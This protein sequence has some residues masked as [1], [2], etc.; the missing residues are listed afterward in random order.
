MTSPCTGWEFSFDSIAALSDPWDKLDADVQEIAMVMA[1]ATMRRLTAFA[2]G[3][4]PVTVRPCTEG[5]RATSVRWLQDAPFMDA[6]GNWLNTCGC[7][8]GADCHC[9]GLLSQID[10]V[11]GHSVS[12]V[13]DGEALV[14]GEDFR[15][16]GGRWLVRLG[17][18]AWPAC[19][20][21]SLSEGDGTFLVT[22]T[23]GLPVGTFGRVAGS[24]LAL[25]MAK[26]LKGAADCALP[27]G[28]TQIVRQGVTMQLSPS[29]F[30][31]GV[32][33]IPAVDS[34]IAAV[35]PNG[36]RMQPTIWSPQQ[37]TFRG[38][39]TQ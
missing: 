23:P 1:G 37:Q 28:V 38:G 8:R 25:E 5:C 29:S 21:M 32:T 3:G 6:A 17:G 18:A 39:V 16:D 9:G 34:Y 22:Y 13:L 11:Q 20:D 26:A 7:G 4:C 15:M 27:K 24:F 2:Y 33:G 36:L 14:S 10:L 30:P 12:V 19:Q 31:G 35:N